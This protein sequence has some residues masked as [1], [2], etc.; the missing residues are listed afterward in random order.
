M[1][2]KTLYEE[3]L[4]RIFTSLSVNYPH[5]Y[6]NMNFSDLAA[7]W[8]ETFKKYKIPADKLYSCYEEVVHYKAEASNDFGAISALD[9]LS[10]YKRLEAAGLKKK[11]TCEICNGNGYIKAFSI[12]LGKDTIFECPNTH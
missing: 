7:D 2:D 5:L 6:K 10:A 3:Q 11:I 12:V 8:F 1:S 4:K 9:M